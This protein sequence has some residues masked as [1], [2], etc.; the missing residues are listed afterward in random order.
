MLSSSI[1]G[2]STRS[3]GIEIDDRSAVTLIEEKFQ[4][5]WEHRDSD[6]SRRIADDRQTPIGSKQLLDVHRLCARNR[7][8]AGHTVEHEHGEPQI[9][10][11]LAKRRDK[12]PRAR[13]L[14]PA[15]DRARVHGGH[16]IGAD[17]RAYAGQRRQ[18]PASFPAMTALFDRQ[19]LRA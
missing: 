5:S 18:A 14:P 19:G 15:H 2:P 6:R 1:S 10:I 8:R 9:G 17:D 13:Q 7:V 11:V 12:N 16:S 3:L 4:Q